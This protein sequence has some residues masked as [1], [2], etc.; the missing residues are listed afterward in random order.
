MTEKIAL[1]NISP[2]LRSVTHL[3]GLEPQVVDLDY[4][5]SLGIQISPNQETLDRLVKGSHYFKQRLEV[6]TIVPRPHVELTEIDLNSQ[7]EVHNYTGA[8]PVLTYEINPVLGCNVGCL[9]CLVTDGVHEQELKAF[10]NYHLLVRR[11]LEEKYGEQHYYYFSP[12]TEAFQ[13]PTLQTG[14][15]HNILREF[16]AHFEKHP[17]SQARLF[18]ASKAGD[19]QLMVEHEGERIIDLFAKLK[20]R[21]QFNT[22]VS[23]MPEYLRDAL[24]PFAAPLDERLKAVLLC[25]EYGVMSD[26]A[27]IQPIVAPYLNEE[28]LHDFFGKL[29]AANIINFKPEFLTACMEN[30][31]MI[32]QLQGFYDKTLEKTLYEYYISPENSDHRK[33]RGRTAPNRELS[34]Q[35][36]QQMMD[37][38]EQYGLSTSI[39]YWVRNQLKIS[40]D[41]IPMVNRNGFQCLGYQ[42]RLFTNPA[43]DL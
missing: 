15:A 32:G 5:K 21:M 26:S 38:G 28:V 41:M 2:N 43:V 9:Y 1:N 13:E 29:R 7:F 17:D 20:D 25:Q 6:G 42:R 30:L 14:I 23:I 3:T 27:L 10:T 35:Y 22:S 19:K 31:A 16:I 8:C 11:I 18:I 40:T 12:K 34:T 4:L 39:C 36:L 24:E 33:Q 37:I